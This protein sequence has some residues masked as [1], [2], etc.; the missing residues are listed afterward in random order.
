MAVTSIWPI[1]GNAAKVIA[2]VRNPEKTVERGSEEMANL[3]AIGGVIEYAADELKT[4]SRAYVTC[5][6]CTNEETAA[7]EFM[8]TKKLKNKTTGRQCFHGYQ[9][10]KAGEVDAETAHAIGVKL[11]ERLWGDRF[12]VVIATHL[13]TGVF[14]NHLVLNSVSWVDGY[15]FD[16]RR[17]DYRAI[18]EESDRLCRE[19]GLSVI[20]YP[21]GR[22]KHYAEHRAENEGQP[23]HRSTI[24]A[25]I[26][27]AVK[28]CVTQR[29]FFYFLEDAGYEFKLYKKNGDLLTYPGLKPPGAKGFFRFHKLGSG[30]DY[31]EVMKRISRNIRRRQPFPEEEQEKVQEHRRQ[32]Q[33]PY[34]KRRTGLYGLYLRY[35][36]E[37]HIIKAH[38]ASVQRVSFFMREDLARLNRLDAQTRLLG[39]A[40][41]STAEELVTHKAELESKITSLTEKRKE[42]RKEARSCRRCGEPERADIAKAEAAA[43]SKEL[44]KLR[45]E[46]RLCDEIMLRSA[47]T[48]EELERL[49]D[50]QQEYEY[51]K[52]EK[53]DEL[54]RGRGGTDRPYELGGR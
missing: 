9:S 39:K 8:E 25:D 23:T 43:I 35:C 15:H 54:F 38:P 7:E 29:E 52:E 45:K 28:A 16:N 26:D 49:L 47:E 30:Y 1:S 36:Y 4:E 19:Y 33:P 34:Q 14:H 50:S 48:R 17:S 20:E 10:F 5:L 46:V 6:N 21:Q 41:I 11:A 40:G 53:Q 2:Y 24:R 44:W 51:G 42:L 13:N 37:L 3:H 18:R 22:G 31:D 32:S 12:Q 27:R